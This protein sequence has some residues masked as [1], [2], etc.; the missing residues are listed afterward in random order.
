MS[1]IKASAD[2]ERVFQN[3]Q[4]ISSP[5]FT[6]LV[7]ETPEQRDQCG[8]VA[9]AAGKKLGN[10]VLR[11]RCKRVMREAVRRKGGPWPGYDVVLVARR[12]VASADVERIDGCL[13]ELI[14]RSK[15]LDAAAQSGEKHRTPRVRRQ[16]NDAEKGGG[17]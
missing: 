15:I 3:G 14:C 11:N 16:A 4:R 12:K 2:I 8:R 5:L 7:D 13:D 17:V 9:F 10:A 1:T 6:L